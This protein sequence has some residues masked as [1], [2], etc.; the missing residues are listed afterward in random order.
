MSGGVT[1]SVVAQR[2]RQEEQPK[3]R[4]KMNTKLKNISFPF[5]GYPQYLS[6]KVLTISM[7]TIEEYF[8][9]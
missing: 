2:E 3:M 5:L 1:V 6:M 4:E 7:G 8:M 9:A